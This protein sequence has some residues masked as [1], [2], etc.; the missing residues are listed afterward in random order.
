MIGIRSFA[1]GALV[2]AAAVA[3]CSSTGATQSVAGVNASSAP[4]SAAASAA[5]GGY[6][7]NGGSASASMSA[8]ASSAAAASGTTVE[9]K[10]AGSAGTVLVAGSNGMTVYTFSM[11]TA[12]SGTSN[13]TGGCASTWPPLTVSAGTTPTAGP[14]VSGKLGTIKL[15]DGSMQVTYNGLPLYFFHG[16]SA[17][18]DTNGHYTNWNLVKP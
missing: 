8:A 9:A 10:T 4:A 13:C 17:P 11:D 12:N 16:D 14:G 15:A 3:A 7:G 6:Y 2:L 1:V 5:S 18:G